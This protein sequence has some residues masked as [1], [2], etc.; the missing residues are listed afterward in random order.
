MIWTSI[1]GIIALVGLARVLGFAKNPALDTDTART[2]VE[3]ALPGFVA[4]AAAVDPRTRTATVTASDG[5]VA[6]VMSHGDR[7]VVRG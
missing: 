3:A 7:W 1:L 5:R 4:T 6:Q 2:V